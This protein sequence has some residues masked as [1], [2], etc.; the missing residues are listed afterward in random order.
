MEL[1]DL[2]SKDIKERLLNGDYG[3]VNQKQDK[4]KPVSIRSYRKYEGI[5]SQY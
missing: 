5:P 1:L 3:V 4:K 2:R